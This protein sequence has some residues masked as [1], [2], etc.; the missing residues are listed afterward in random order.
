MNNL[1]SVLIEGTLT[2]N[3]MFNPSDINTTLHL[4]ST[5]T[6]KTPN[7]GEITEVSHFTV[8]AYGQ[9]AER[10]ADYLSKGRE[11]RII[12]RLKETT[13]GILIVADHVEII[14][15]AKSA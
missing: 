4:E 13:D 1:N 5:R 8:I 7:D 10:C 2:R 12:G 9:Q 3:P 11:V 14:P 6:F 15:V